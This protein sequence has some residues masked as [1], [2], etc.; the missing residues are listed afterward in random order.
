MVTLDVPWWTYRA[1]DDV[2]DWLAARDRPA[3]V[4]E[5]GSGAST[6]W[7]ARRSGSVHSVEH[8]TGFA[9]LMDDLLAD[10]ANAEVVVRPPVRVR[11]ARRAVGEGGV[12][13]PRLRV[14]RRR[15]R[16]GRRRLR[17]GRG[18]RPCPR[19]LP[20]QG[21]RRASRRTGSSSST[22]PG[23]VATAARSTAAPVVERRLPGLTP[24][25]PYPDQTSLLR[26][27]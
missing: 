26:R 18:R 13:R 5:Y 22:T 21:A 1:I 17:P 15:D 9:A 8:D 7:L 14:V 12:R 19:A 20:D 3:R 11:H 16:R 27:S 24:T 2:E 6:V 4:F 10:V 23:D 25:L